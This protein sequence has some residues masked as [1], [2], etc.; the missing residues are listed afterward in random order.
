MV[1]LQVPH[2][3]RACPYGEFSDQVH[4]F[5]TLTLYIP[6]QVTKVTFN[7]LPAQEVC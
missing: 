1:Q 5:S 6:L 2:I 3:K 4:V 7:A